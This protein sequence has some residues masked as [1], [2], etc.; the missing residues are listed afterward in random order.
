MLPKGNAAVPAKN[1]IL[2][3]WDGTS[4]T[5]LR[6]LLSSGQLPNLQKLIAEGGLVNTQVTTGKTQTK[7]G[8]AEI[9]TGGSAPRLGITSNRNYK[10]I[11][12]GYTVFERLEKAFGHA[13]IATIFL[14]GKFNN[15]GAWGPHEICWNCVS[16]DA[17]TREKTQWW[18]K[19]SVT[20]TK[21]RDGKP[22]VWVA[23]EGEPYLYTS[24]HVDLYASGLGAAKN[25]GAQALAALDTRA[26]GPFFAFIHF[27]EPDEEGHL[28]GGS[29]KE[30]F[31]AMKSDDY[32]LGEIV[33]K[34]NDNGIYD[35]TTIFVTTD[36]GFE[37]NGFEH[38]YEPKTFLA[39][40]S[41]R[42]LGNG[43][44]KDVT[45]TILEEY[46]ISL[47]NIK[48]PLDG[49]SLFLKQPL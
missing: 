23:R 28:Y 24:K 12:A 48:P 14:T 46:G 9:L 39:T 31:E 18:T 8:W 38:R 21:T 35:K 20:T 16:R 7:P 44:R 43:D 3:G 33:K 15:R 32:W 19:Q 22:P 27:E 47:K 5:H 45:P 11:P 6:K 34:L 17:V 36:H 30:Y 49:K 42:K 40:N 37:E 10:P 26:K 29:S 41:K 1:V 4:R 25:V 2:L 13:N